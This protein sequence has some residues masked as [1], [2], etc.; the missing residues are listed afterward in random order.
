MMKRKGLGRKRSWPDLRYY[1]DICIDGPR[2]TTK[3]SSQDGQSLSPHIN[4]NGKFLYRAQRPKPSPTP[5]A[6]QTMP[7]PKDATPMTQSQTPRT[8]VKAN[9]NSPALNLMK[10]GPLL[11][12]ALPITKRSCA[13]K[14]KQPCP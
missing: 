14:I 7:S 9:P 3:T 12:L 1:P 2:K 13:P 4:I 8:Q 10:P 5:R 11:N 6:H